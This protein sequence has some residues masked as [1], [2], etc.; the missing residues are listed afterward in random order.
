V[1]EV[2]TENAH[3]GLVCVGDSILAAP[4]SWGELLARAAGWGLVSHAARG[5][6]C[7]QVIEQLAS[8]E[9]HRYAVGA[10]SVGA[11]DVLFDWD[12]ERYDA[13]LRA[14]V[15]AMQSSCDRV[16]VQTFPRCFRH[17]PGSSPRRRHAVVVANRMIRFVAAESGAAI[18][19]AGD[20]RGQYLRPDRVHPS[21]R[22]QL[23][24]A[25]RA[26]EVLGLPRRPSDAMTGAR[27]EHSRPRYLASTARTT[28]RE[29]R[30]RRHESGISR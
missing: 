4:R 10:L 25:D 28:V 16:L 30:A 13:T 6:R 24:L 1:A 8:L 23:L 27:N 21:V 3:E 5:A 18:V 17:F 9:G 15:K 20:L 11:N 7:W 29:W 14:I 19:D 22:G 12:A 26:A 2:S